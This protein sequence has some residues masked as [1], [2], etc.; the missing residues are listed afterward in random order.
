[1]R[2]RCCS[3]PDVNAY[4]TSLSPC[5]PPFRIEALADG[6][7]QRAPARHDQRR[8]QQDA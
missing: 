7:E 5:G 6:I 2:S 1:M 3:P 4:R 8:H